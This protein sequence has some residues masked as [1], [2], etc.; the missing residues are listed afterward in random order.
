MSIV[1]RKQICNE[2]GGQARLA[3]ANILT[4]FISFVKAFSS[5][6]VSQFCRAGPLAFS[7]GRK[8][9]GSGKDEVLKRPSSPWQP[10]FRL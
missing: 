5:Q 9:P 1:R 10:A 7:P 2:K 8:R 6:G 3:T 4:Q